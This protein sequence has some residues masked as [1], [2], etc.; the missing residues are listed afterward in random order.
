MPIKPENKASY[1]A[2][3]PAIRERI[4]ER[5]GNRCEQCRVPNRTR[6][7]RGQGDYAGTYMDADANVYSAEDGRH[8]GQCRMSDYDVARM[9]DIVLTIAHL[10]DPDP[11]NCDEANLAAL[12]QRCHNRLDAPMRAVNARATRRARKAV[13][14]LFAEAPH[15][16]PT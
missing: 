4:L 10:H 9:V 15:G 12:C 8:L 16:L 7:A 1:P 14:D 3:W 6:I 5:A 2:D 13:G 11:S